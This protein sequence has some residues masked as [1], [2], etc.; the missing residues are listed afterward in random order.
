M[1]KSV[2]LSDLFPLIKEQLDAGGV[3][4]FPIHGKSMMPMLRDRMDS[5]RIAKP[6]SKPKKYDI[7]F[8]TREDGSFIL[9][10]IVGIKNG[11][12]ICRGDNQIQ[13]ELVNEKQIIAYVTE[14]TKNG[15][16]KKTDSVA[17]KLYSR[18]WVNTVMFRWL[19]KKAISFFRR[20]FK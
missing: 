8:Y 19:T 9:H 5:V 6:D 10:R 3:A 4:S 14:Y 11:I 13:N 17:Q 18:F 12:Y 16:W 2:K 7:I 15:E 20:L 1:N